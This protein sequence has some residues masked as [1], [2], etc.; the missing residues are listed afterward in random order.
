MFQEAIQWN[1]SNFQVTIMK[2]YWKKIKQFEDKPRREPMP[3]SSL[4]E[5]DHIHIAQDR[6]KPTKQPN[7]PWTSPISCLT[8]LVLN[9]SCAKEYE[10]V[11]RS[12]SMEHNKFSK[13]PSLKCIGKGV[14]R[15]KQFDDNPRMNQCQRVA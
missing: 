2:I 14:E 12:H 1:I 13:L 8:E 5:H 10:Y 4:R 15:N 9:V 7:G 6:I 11:P 3:K